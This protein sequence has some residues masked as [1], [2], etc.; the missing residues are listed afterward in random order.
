M[1]RELA[2]PKSR[3]ATTIEATATSSTSL[4]QQQHLTS[5]SAPNY[6]WGALHCS[7]MGEAG[8]IRSPPDDTNLKHIRPDIYAHIHHGKA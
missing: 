3:V 5:V 2:R 4:P 7:H 8:R 1:P 6:G